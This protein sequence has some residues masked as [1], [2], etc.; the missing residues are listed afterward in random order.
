MITRLAI[1]GYRSL[2]DIRLDLGTLTVVTGANGA[3]KSSLYRAL[4]LLADIAQGRVIQS[5][6]AEGG[7]QSTLWAGPE[8]FSRA[9][10]SGEYKVEGTVRRKPIALKLGFTDETFGYAV[11]LGLPVGGSSSFINDPEIKAESLWIGEQLSPRNVIAEW[12]GP[13]VRLRAESGSWRQASTN[14]SPRDSMMTHSAG[15]S[16]AQEV[17]HLRERIRDWRF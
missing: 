1:A 12:R 13:S 15:A 11:D 5:L 17:L 6:A 2:R 9:V 7:L 16:D 10:K 14:L 8:Q 4:R 3:G